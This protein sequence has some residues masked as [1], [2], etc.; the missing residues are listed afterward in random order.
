MVNDISMMAYD[1]AHFMQKI[2]RRVG[3]FAEQVLL[4]Q[5]E[6]DMQHY[7]NSRKIDEHY[8]H[9]DVEAAFSLFISLTGSNYRSDKE[10]ISY[11]KKHFKADKIRVI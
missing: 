7:H 5:A 8:D 2:H 11:L 1:I 3:L 9:Y 6:L 4:P 10:H